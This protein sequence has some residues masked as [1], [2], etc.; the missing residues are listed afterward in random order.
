M[1]RPFRE[2]RG[3]VERIPLLLAICAPCQALDQCAESIIMP[4]NWRITVLNRMEMAAHIADRLDQ[5]RDALKMQFLSSSPIRYFYLDDLLPE[6]TCRRIHACF[7]AENTMRL[8]KSVRELKYISAQMDQHNHLL[9]E[10]IYAFQQPEVVKKIREI[11]GK[12][13][14]LP[15][16]FLYAGGI[17]MMATGHFLNPHIDNSHDKDRNLWRNLN[18]LYYVSPGWSVESGGNLELWPRGV[19][20]KGTTIISKFNRL[21]VM[22]THHEAWHSV[23]KVVAQANRCCVSNYYFA[24]TPVRDKQQFHVT[25]FRGRP[26]QPLRDMVL[27]ADSLLRMGIRALFKRGI[28]EN[29]H[30]YVKSASED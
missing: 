11:T 8:R 29:K 12:P 27:R 5:Q 9:E 24:P 20:E 22:E 30:K 14:L 4:G 28:V 15:D 23:S 1:E 19:K 25:S 17:S 7:P 18:L 16:E 21:A 13:D 26:E 10:A 6:E 2:G 3:S